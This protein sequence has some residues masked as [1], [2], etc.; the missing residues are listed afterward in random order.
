MSQNEISEGGMPGANKRSALTGWVL[1]IIRAMQADGID[2]DQVLFELGMDPSLLEG[3]YSRYSQ[4]QVS[5]LWRRA[6]D[7]TGNSHFGL[8]VAQQV[9]PATFHVVG[10]SMSCSATV[11]RALQRFAKY[12]R[13]ISD[14][15]T[16][17]LTEAAGQVV[18]EFHFDTGG[19]PPIYQTVDTV[20]ASVVSFLRW[21]LNDG[22]RPEEVRFAHAETDDARNFVEFFG[23][24]IIFNAA[25]TCL[26]FGKADVDRKILSSDEELASLLDNAASRSLDERMVGRFS[27][28]VRDLLI[29]QL[30]HDGP[31]KA[32]ITKKL[33]MTERTLLRRLKSEGTTFAD[34]LR[35]VREELAFQYLR[36]GM[37]LSE[38][39]Y[40]LGF[41]DDGTFSRAF[42]DW[43]GRRPSTVVV[44]L[45][46]TTS[47]ETASG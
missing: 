28:R 36:R 18:L 44:D 11:L 21:I 19:P 29:A 42:K 46:P 43:T 20:L 34:V 1:A 2:T 30:P 3:G 24:P 26:V 6:T 7:M 12:C 33:G 31:S 14:S 37:C 45:P 13:L 5:A 39:A 47:L 40:L 10:Y 38:V 17:T 4:G 15:T 25:Q 32:K 27:I 23:C 9:R 8:Q 41:S 22:L 35:Q 16:A